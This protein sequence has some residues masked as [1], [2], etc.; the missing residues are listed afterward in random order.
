[1]TGDLVE[2]LRSAL[3][4]A[5]EIA[6]AATPG[7]WWDSPAQTAPSHHTIRG[8]GR[9]PQ[10]GRPGDVRSVARFD[11]RVNNSDADIAFIAFIVTND[12]AVVLRTIQ[13]HREIISD[14]DS[15]DFPYDPE[16][17]AHGSYSWQPCCVGCGQPEP[18]KTLQLIAAIYL[19]DI[20]T[21]DTE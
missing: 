19:P 13:A 12:P 2:R 15:S 14:H 18:C 11:R 4:R 7:P 10:K 8:G 9:E 6:R 5:E 3:D 17:S 1:V 20:E 21:G 16:G